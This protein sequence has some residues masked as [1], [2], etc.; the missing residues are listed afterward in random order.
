MEVQV[1]VGVGGIQKDVPVGGDLVRLH[2]APGLFEGFQAL[3]AVAELQVCVAQVRE[4]AGVGDLLLRASELGGGLVED[5]KR[6]APASEVQ[7]NKPP[8]VADLVQL[9]ASPQ[10]REHPLRGEVGPDRLV[11]ASEVLE[12]DAPVHVRERDD[13]ARV[14][15]VVLAARVAL[16]PER[17]EKSLTDLQDLLVPLKAE[18][19]AHPSGLGAQG[20]ELQAE[21]LVALASEPGEVQRSLELPAKVVVASEHVVRLRDRRRSPVRKLQA[22]LREPAG[23]LGVACEQVVGEVEQP[24]EPPGIQETTFFEKRPARPGVRRGEQRR[25]E[26]LRGGAFLFAG[27]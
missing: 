9:R 19:L 3:H 18:E 15:R 26:V 21:G 23:A 2:K 17:G 20:V 1:G 4:G 11:V 5:L 7:Q 10:A 12:G 6:L 22:T 24:V 14:L 16:L 27:F 25:K 8:V 13:D